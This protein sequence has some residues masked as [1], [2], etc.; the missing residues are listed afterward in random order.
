VQETYISCE[1]IFLSK[2]TSQ[3]KEGGDG[4][5]RVNEHGKGTKM[6]PARLH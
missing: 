2:N 6:L 5:R 4:E 3:H 1:D